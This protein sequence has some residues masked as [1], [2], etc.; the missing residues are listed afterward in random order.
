VCDPPPSDRVNIYKEDNGEDSLIKIR[1]RSS[2]DIG[3][4]DLVNLSAKRTWRLY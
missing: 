2:A 1:G 4:G 3:V